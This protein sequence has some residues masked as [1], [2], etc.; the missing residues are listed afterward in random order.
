[1]LVLLSIDIQTIL[2]DLYELNFDSAGYR[3]QG[4]LLNGLIISLYN[5]FV[6][7]VN[8]LGLIS[9]YLPLLVLQAFFRLCRIVYSTQ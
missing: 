8:T 5:S 7:Q 6:V 1:M 2:G 4:Y 3:F 9:A